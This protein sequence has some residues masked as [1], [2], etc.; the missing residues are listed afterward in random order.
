[1]TDYKYYDNITKKMRRRCMASLNDRVKKYGIDFDFQGDNRKDR[2]KALKEMVREERN[3]RLLIAGFTKPE[4]P[5]KVCKR[6]EK[7]SLKKAFRLIK[8]KKIFEG[9]ATAVA[10]DNSTVATKT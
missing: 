2:R 6:K 10:T 1:M 8:K 4:L 5:E 3:N 7:L 9:V